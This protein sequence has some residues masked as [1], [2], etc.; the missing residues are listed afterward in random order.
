MVERVRLTDKLARGYAAPEKGERVVYD[1]D[2]PLLYIRIRASGAKSWWI[3]KG[4]DKWNLGRV[5]D[6]PVADART[7]ALKILALRAQGLKPGKEVNPTVKGVLE[8]YMRNWANAECKP[9]TLK[10]YRHLIDEYIVPRFGEL[11]ADEL[12][13]VHIDTMRGELA[14]RKATWNKALA[15]LKAAF[16]QGIRWKMRNPAL[17]NPCLGAKMYSIP[18]RDTYLTAEELSGIL[19]ALDDVA[20]RKNRWHAAQCL[21]TLA[22]TGCR[23]DE[24]R[25]VHERWVDWKEGIIRWP[26]T[27]TGKGELILSGTAIGILMSAKKHPCM[28]DGKPW[29]FRGMN[30][31]IPLP[32]S[33]LYKAWYEAL[34]LAV[35]K[36][37]VDDRRIEDLHPHD[38]RH[39]F[40]SLGL[41]SGLSLADIQHLLRHKDSRSTARYAKHIPERKRELADASESFLGLSPAE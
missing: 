16:Q 15:L 5:V 13:P 12:G 7:A 27:K 20:Q 9:R 24:L 30:N 40:A 18:E 1:L 37:G 36:Y 4:S 17:G 21:R 35:E 26:D 29:L 38:L 34:D 28:K 8:A 33:T 25:L 39:S 2:V 41:S 14:D 3:K 19:S 31:D 23:R 6:V 22:V 10:S 11:E 32:E